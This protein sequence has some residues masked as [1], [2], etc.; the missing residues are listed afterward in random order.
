M[1]DPVAVEK[2]KFCATK[3]FATYR[4]R[5][6]FTIGV[7]IVMIVDAFMNNVSFVLLIV[8]TVIVLVL[9]VSPDIV[10]NPISI[11]VN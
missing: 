11:A 4:S 8:D 1:V 7:E 2:N 3:L 6:T 10:M 5:L 9:T